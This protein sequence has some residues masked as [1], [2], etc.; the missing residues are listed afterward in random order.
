MKNK[1]L[2]FIFSLMIF[3]MGLGYSSAKTLEEV[4]EHNIKA[5]E[6]Y[7]F[8]FKYINQEDNIKRNVEYLMKD[9]E[10]TSDFY[11]KNINKL[12]SQFFS[13][14]VFKDL[15]NVL[16]YE[17]IEA[18]DMN[19]YYKGDTI[20]IYKPY[21]PTTTTVADKDQCNIYILYKNDGGDYSTTIY[22]N[23]TEVSG[24]KTISKETASIA[25]DLY[26]LF[27]VADIDMINHLVNYKTDTT[28][29]FSSKNAPYEFSKIKKIK[30]ENPKYNIF[31]GFEETRRGIAMTGVANGISYVSYNDVIYDFAYDTFYQSQF[32]YVPLN[33]N[34]E[35]YGKVLLDKIKNY[36]K[37]DSVEISIT[38]G[39]SN[40]WRKSKY[41]DISEVLENINGITASDYYKMI[42]SDFNTEYAKLKNNC[43]EEG[44]T[45]YCNDDEYYNKTKSVILAKLY[46]LNINGKDYEI[47]ILPM[48]DEHSKEY[49]VISSTDISSGIIIRT[50]SGNVPFDASLT[51]GLYNLTDEEVKLLNNN[52]YGAINAYSF[53]LYSSILDKIISNFN[54]VTEVLIPYNDNYSDKNLKM[55]YIKDNGKLEVYDINKVTYEGKQYLSFNTSHFSNYIL[56]YGDISNPNTSDN[57]ITYIIILIV[58]LLGAAVGIILNKKKKTNTKKEL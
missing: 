9:N 23:M 44:N 43:H 12:R 45:S 33:T 42:G 51:T 22:G 31:V 58:A 56:A 19:C 21:E 5:L 48:D 40:E 32:F 49:G 39:S 6:E 53:K 27:H 24:D 16:D 36:V 1:L 30:E 38:E 34:E 3:F 4:K 47:G 52:G 10:F 20:E 26:G 57:I 13:Y 18:I 2:L 46:N 29:F 14:L 35:D 55:I 37:D 7:T 11:D 17:G 28:T 41:M 8:N 15:N 54:G 50:K 25:K